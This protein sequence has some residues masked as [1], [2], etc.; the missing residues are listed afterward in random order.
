MVNTDLDYSHVTQSGFFITV[1][2]TVD[3]TVIYCGDRWSNNTN[4]GIGYN[5]WCPLSFVG[6]DVIFNSLSQWSIDAVTGTWKIGHGN[7]Y[8]LNPS[9]EADRI[10]VGSVIGWQGNDRN[11]DGSPGAGDF[12]LGLGGGREGDPENTRKPDNSRNA[13]WYL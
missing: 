8:I 3:T 10:K 11:A 7:N 12:C 6:D 4:N 13:Q 9:F 2:S 5:Q 1:N